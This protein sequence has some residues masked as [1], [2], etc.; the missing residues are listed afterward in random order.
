MNVEQQWAATE[1]VLTDGWPGE[2]TP[3]SANVYRAVLRRFPADVVFQAAQELVAAGRQYRPRIAEVAAECHRLMGTQADAAEFDAPPFAEVATVC[4][5][6]AWEFDAVDGTTEV[7]RQLGR[8]AAAWFAAAGRD[9]IRAAQLG[10]PDFGARE[11]DRVRGSYSEW[12]G[13]QRGRA[14]KG[15]TVTTVEDGVLS[16]GGLRHLDPAKALGLPGAGA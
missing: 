16:R 2:F 13:A 12:V 3:E 14:R 11:R 5:S 9:M 4:E 10:D 6:A 8:V 7:E 15:L 1:L